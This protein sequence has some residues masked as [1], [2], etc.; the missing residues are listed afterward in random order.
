MHLYPK[1]FH[2]L[3][4]ILVQLHGTKVYKELEDLI[5]A[6]LCAQPA[7]RTVL[8]ERCG[9]LWASP[10]ITFKTSVYWPASSSTLL[11]SPTQPI[12]LTSSG[13]I[14]GVRREL[15]GKSAKAAAGV[16]TVYWLV[17]LCAPQPCWFCSNLLPEICASGVTAAGAQVCTAAS[18]FKIFEVELM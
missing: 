16:V 10:A 2:A 13:K 3:S 8:C 1:R 6:M 17:S 4:Q 11:P 9:L 7:L 12:D 14:S 18:F 5:S 15:S